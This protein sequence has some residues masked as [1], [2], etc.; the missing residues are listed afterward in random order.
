MWRFA[1]AYT[2]LAV[3]GRTISVGTIISLRV[4]GTD[5][6]WAKNGPGEN[7]GPLFQDNDRTRLRSE[8]LDYDRVDPNDPDLAREE[9]AFAKQLS[10]LVPRLELLGFTLEQVEAEYSQAVQEHAEET[11]AVDE[12]DGGLSPHLMTFP[13]FCA[14]VSSHPI[15]ELDDT[16]VGGLASDATP[17]REG[18]F[19]GKALEQRIPCDWNCESS[20]S[21]R[22]YFA[23][24]MMFLNPYSI[25]RVLAECPMNAN[26]QV[27]W[28]FGPVVCSGW[29]AERHFLPGPSRTQTFLIATEGSSDTH[30]LKHAFSLLRPGIE[31]FFRFIDMKDGHPFP[32]TGNL[33]KF[34]RGL[35]KID[36][37][38]QVV[39]LLD[40][41]AEGML[42]Y[43]EIQSLALP[44]SMRA[45]HLP[46]LDELCAIPARGPEG[47]RP[48]DINGRAA[49]IECYL[50][51]DAPGPTPTEIRWTNYKK[52]L[53]AY[54]GALCHK[55]SFAKA[56]LKQ[57]LASLPKYD[58][59]KM[60]KV[61]DH[62]VGVCMDMAA[63]CSHL[64]GE[65]A[66][67]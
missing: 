1:V 13:E 14:F 38:N 27:D 29:A 37:H 48:T 41:D 35:A 43:K 59:R 22:S 16:F 63:R 40:N 52:E 39:F 65:S 26:A 66:L 19:F 28:Q 47:V 67:P 12:K 60:S 2:E 36:V 46:P 24:L 8:Q 25:L 18:R 55:E 3:K 56:F 44:P 10:G 51:F 62:I 54:Q 57:N 42:A 53:N 7:Y 4:A 6:A 31:N 9:M 61:L 30:I 45:T 58:T 50:D 11:E 64:T 5:I 34:A 49:A 17:H 21:E 20:Y 23:S 15:G 32:G 33:V